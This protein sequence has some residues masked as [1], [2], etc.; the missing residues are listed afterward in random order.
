M[1]VYDYTGV[2]HL[3]SVLS[4]DGQAPL[5]SILGDAGRCGID[6]LMLTDHDHLQGKE[7]GWEGWQGKT[8]LIV[9][10]EIS[11]RFNHY[12]AFNIRN[13]LPFPKE[14]EDI[15][16]QTYIDEVHA[17]GGFGFIA[18]PDH[19]GAPMFHVKHYAWK[20]W[21]VKGY[22]GISIW[23][24]MTDW[25]S[26][27]KG[28]ASALL[29]FIFPARFLKGPRRVT[30]ERWDALNQAGR[31]VGI[32]ELDN[33][34]SIKKLLGITFVAFPFHRAFHFI[35]T[36]AL[37]R[38]KLTGQSGPDIARIFEAITT[39]RCYVA[40]EYFR[41]ARGFEFNISQKETLFHMGDCLPLSPNI[42]L[43]VK[44]P[45]PAR[46][47]LIRNGKAETEVIAAELSYPA[48]KT[49]VYRVEVYLKAA[50]KFRPW[51]F[52]NPIFVT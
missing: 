45:A 7:N 47:R 46:I 33:H 36:H 44:L 43:C 14:A 11:P 48:V 27:L 9:G 51:I 24:F 28:Y 26:S 49:G 38:E 19:E 30:L 5:E 40:C 29:S 1:D 50:G 18:H 41:E 2:I 23:D 4:Y 25:Q 42:K 37:T 34:A 52:S 20:D 22:T 35:R 32:G 21:T 16:P 10:Q 12:L 13:P 6:F 3:H 31:V 15:L 17:Q 39:G 8:L